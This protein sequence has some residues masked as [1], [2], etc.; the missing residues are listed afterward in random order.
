MPPLQPWTTREGMRGSRMVLLALLS[1]QAL[2]ERPGADW[3]SSSSSGG[4][5][6]SGSSRSSNE[7]EEMMGR[8]RWNSTV[9]TGSFAVLLQGGAYRHRSRITYKIGPERYS[10][11][12][13]QRDFG[14]SDCDA[15]C[16]A[17]FRFTLPDLRR[18][19]CALRL[20]AKINTGHGLVD[21]EEALLI[22]L[23]RLSYP[24]TYATLAWPTGRHPAQIS[25]IFNG[26]I[27]HLYSSLTHLRDSRS[28]ECWGP[29]FPRFA[30]AIHRGGRRSRRRAYRPMP[31]TNC[32]GFIDGSNQY[33]DKPGMYQHILYNGHKRA[34][35]V[36]WQGIML[37]NGIMP[38][39]FGP[40]HGRNHDALM[41]EYSGVIPAMRRISAGLGCDYQL[42]GDPAYPLSPYLGAPFPSTILLNGAEAQFN[43]DM[44]RSRIAVEWGFGKVKGN[45]AYLDFEKGMKPYLNDIQ[46]YWP[47]AQIL[48]NCHT[49]LYGNQTSNYFNLPP[50]QL[51][52]YLAMG[53]NLPRY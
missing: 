2:S 52:V 11:A 40:V 46:R 12:R 45:F 3:D 38:M 23:R 27:R 16:K 39:P 47:V 5:G 48:T 33:T 24:A 43:V 7:W 31:L 53:S 18:L 17:M 21:S 42:Y 25:R 35:C 50:P 44:S 36:K 28:L 6:S 9:A 41:L 22:M 49:C 37:P 4:S 34:H 19:H 26:M 30:A 29:H 1:S 20:P 8:A 32:V 14:R 10:F 13:L 15:S 51:E